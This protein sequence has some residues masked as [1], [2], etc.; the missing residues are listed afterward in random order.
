MTI[1]LFAILGA[2][3]NAGAGYWICFAIYCVMFLIK[4]IVDV[5]RER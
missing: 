4:T 1:V 5:V 2:I 3:V